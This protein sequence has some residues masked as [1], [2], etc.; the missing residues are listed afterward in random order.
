LGKLNTLQIENDFTFIV[1]DNHYNCPWFI[2]EF[3]SP[4]VSE[5]R[6]IDITMKEF[7]IETKDP[8]RLF[9]SILSLGCGSTIFMSEESFSF[10]VSISREL[11]NWE[12][13]F[14]LYEIFNDNLSI[15]TFCKEFCSFEMT[16]DFPERGIEFLSSHFY[17]IDSSFL[18]GLPI[19]IVIRILSNSSLKV[20]TE[21]LLYRMIRSEIERNSEFL[22]LFSFVRFEFLSV[23]SIEDFTS[24]SCEYFEIF[25]R[26]FSQ[27]LWTA[28]C[29]RLRLSVDVEYRT[30][31]YHF[32]GLHFIPQTPKPLSGIISYLTFH[33]S[34]NVHDRGIVNVSG[35]TIHSSCVAKCAVDLLSTSLF[36][37]LGES[38]QWLCYDFKNR[39]V[40][41]THYSIHGYPNCYLRSWV[42]EGSIDGSTW[43]ELDR[44][45]DDQTMNS[46]HRIG[47]FSISN[48]CEYQFVRLR[49]TG[50][51]A[52][53]Y[54]H[55]LLFAMEI[56]GDLIE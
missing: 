19:S 28:I 52:N 44:H 42:F 37:S 7:L 21:D 55:L 10:F 40:R 8:G 39:K 27:N 32:D 26:F 35:S 54:H 31:R 45:T 29:C 14:R 11:C 15:S 12:L 5:L 47:T 41:P 46:N 34:G 22:E 49:Q 18:K 56:F 2:A 43:T 3:L 17:E 16:E 33:H 20:E 1:G 48:D 4:R 30:E 25:E 6:S 23:E 53:G 50:V 13:Y 51:N 9:E 38:N 36:H 24:W